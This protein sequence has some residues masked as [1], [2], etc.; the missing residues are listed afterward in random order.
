MSK[1]TTNTIKLKVKKLVPSAVIPQKAKQGDAGID[2][3]TLSKTAI[4]GHGK[5]LVSTGIAVEIPEGY[6]GLICDRS[7]L[8]SRTGLH[9][10]AGVIDSGYRGELKVL[11]SNISYM[12]EKINPGERVAQLIIMPIP[13]LE[14]IDVGE[15]ELSNSER[16][17]T[18]FGSTD[19]T[20]A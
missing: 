19:I 12:P 18:G 3:T 17:D 4:P 1:L 20:N 5:L 15:E 8:S 10:N 14:I 9:V 16:K 11:L 2:L 13:N 7:G 6:Y